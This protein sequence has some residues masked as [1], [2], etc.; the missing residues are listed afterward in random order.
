ML[1]QTITIEDVF[2]RKLQSDPL[3]VLHL[4]REFLEQGPCDGTY[5][6]QV[7]DKYILAWMDESEANEEMGRRVLGLELV[8]L[9]RPV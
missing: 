7:I 1:K 2:V 3:H 4:T 5:A 6:K 8:N 9:L